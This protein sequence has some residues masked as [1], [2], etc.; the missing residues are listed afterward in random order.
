MKLKF[1]TIGVYGVKEIEFFK[2]LISHNIDVF[3]DIRLRRGMRGPKYAFA[4]S[5]YLQAKLASLGIRYFHFKEL[6]PTK[7]IRDEQKQ[8]DK[9]KAVKK[10]DRQTLSPEFI[11]AYESKILSDFNSAEF[12]NKLGD[13]A[14]RVVLFCVEHEPDACHRSLAAKRLAK[15]LNIQVE[16]I[17]P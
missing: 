8:A 1:F 6:A 2:A 9:N 11:H 13:N 17:I 16:H 14:E 4:N 12:I 10:R 7:A 5:K 15:D 3:C